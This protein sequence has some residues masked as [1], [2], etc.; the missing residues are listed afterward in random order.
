[1]LVDL[2]NTLYEKYKNERDSLS[3]EKKILNSLYILYSISLT[4]KIDEEEAVHFP[5][6]KLN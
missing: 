1:M 4:D 3:I 2:L 6:E 5:I